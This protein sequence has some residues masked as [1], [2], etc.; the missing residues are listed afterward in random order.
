[1]A[2]IYYLKCPKDDTIRYIGQTKNTLNKRLLGHFYEFK[3]LCK[4]NKLSTHKDFWFRSLGDDYKKITIHF[5]EEVDESSISQRELE[6]ILQYKNNGHPITNT[7]FTE[8]NYF[9]SEETRKKISDSKLGSKNGMFGR[10]FTK[11]EADVEKAR[12]AMITSDKFQSSRKSQEYRKKISEIQAVALVAL[13]EDF[14]FYKEFYNTK[15]C[16]EH[17]GLKISNIHH[18]VKD[19]RKIGKSLPTKYWIVKKE[20]YENDRKNQVS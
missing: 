5:L 8:K 18:A 17:F 7:Q 20:D 14:S 10:R 12:Q 15:E 9:H 6:L 19:K 4:K 16:A 3:V 13:T 11:S 1:M 2:F